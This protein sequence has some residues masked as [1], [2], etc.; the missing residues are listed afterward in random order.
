[1][2]RFLPP[3]MLAL[4]LAGAAL[5]QE[6]SPIAAPAGADAPYPHGQAVNACAPWDGAAVTFNFTASPVASIEEAGNVHPRLGLS[7]Y[8]ALTSI[9][10]ATYEIGKPSPDGEM[11][12]IRGSLVTGPGQYSP[13]RSGTITFDPLPG[14]P[15]DV[16]EI[17]LTGSY[18]LTVEGA[19]P[20]KGR[21]RVVFRRRDV[22]CG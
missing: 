19:G 4:V 7:I 15:G 5:A 21:F 18:E 1:M 10:G 17:T 2:P 22:I 11:E 9:S 6:P 20:L 13:L 8:E 12:R 16:S 14:A 3:L